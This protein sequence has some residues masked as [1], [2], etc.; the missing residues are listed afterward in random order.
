MSPFLAIYGYNPPSITS[1]LKGNTNF[2]AVDEHIGNQQEVL[3]VLKDNLV[4]AQ[5]KMKQQEYQYHSEREFDVGYWL[6]FSLQPYK[7]MYLKK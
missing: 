5:N 3:K 6:F 2:Q 1:P 7:H 4:L